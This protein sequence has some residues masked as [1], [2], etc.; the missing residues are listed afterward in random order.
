MGTIAI[1]LQLIQL[2]PAILQL[3][4]QVE[5]IVGAGKGADKKAMVMA[6]LS[7]A[8]EAI[9]KGVSNMIDSHVASLN[10]MNVFKKA[11]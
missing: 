7:T 4:V 10:S 3:I 11:V 5:G 9:Q 8:P 1:I 6:P 2:A